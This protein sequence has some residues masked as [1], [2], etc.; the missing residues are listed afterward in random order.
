MQ[1]AE[2]DREES[3]RLE[4][5]IAFM[6]PISEQA[7][8]YFSRCNDIVYDV[9]ND[10]NSP[11]ANIDLSDPSNWPRYALMWMFRLLRY[12]SNSLFCFR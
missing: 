10:E 12:L 9:E 4:K 7:L 6:E 3:G 11:W 8:E 2:F 1:L 5:I